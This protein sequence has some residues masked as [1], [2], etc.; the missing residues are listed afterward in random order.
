[1]TGTSGLFMCVC[2]ILRRIL[3]LQWWGFDV[4][5]VCCIQVVGVDLV[6]V[7]VE[8]SLGGSAGSVKG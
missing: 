6:A 1:M 5:Y 2:C 4:G 7:G 8:V 3:E